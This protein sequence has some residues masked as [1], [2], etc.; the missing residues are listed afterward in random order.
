MNAPSR[1]RRDCGNLEAGEVAVNED[2]DILCRSRRDCGNL[3][4]EAQRRIPAR[5]PQRRSRRDC[6]NLEAVDI[7]P[8]GIG[9][10]FI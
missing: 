1:S 5:R 7:R 8:Q 6:G 10:L 3:E 4:A 2:S 9:Q